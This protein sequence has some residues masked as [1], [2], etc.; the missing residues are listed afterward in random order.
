[1]TIDGKEGV[2]L[3][4]KLIPVGIEG[5]KWIVEVSLKDAVGAIHRAIADSVDHI[6]PAADMIGSSRTGL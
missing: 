2:D 6:V 5:E 4:K 1:L 3:L